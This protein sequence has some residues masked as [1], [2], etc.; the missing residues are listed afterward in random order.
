[1]SVKG[2]FSM[3]EVK[4]CSA[5]CGCGGSSCW[6]G[7]DECCGCCV[8]GFCCVVLLSYG[9]ACGGSAFFIVMFA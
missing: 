4:S 7:V 8:V 3:S 5:V 6:I 9:L 1:M 2:S